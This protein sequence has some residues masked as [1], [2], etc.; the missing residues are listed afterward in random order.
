MT[1]LNFTLTTKTVCTNQTLGHSLQLCVSATCTVR[2]SL[3]MLPCEHAWKISK[4]NSNQKHHWGILP[5]AIA[6]QNQY[7]F[8]HRNRWACSC[9]AGYSARL[10]SRMKS[11]Q[12]GIDDWTN[13]VAM[14]CQQSKI[15]SQQ[16]TIIQGFVIPLSAMAIVRMSKFLFLP[17]QVNDY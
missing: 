3:S 8:N 14:I 1:E 2:E 16:L 11:G 9:Y 4:I 15:P 13:I 7:N 10:L 5:L 12:S 17:L 6:K